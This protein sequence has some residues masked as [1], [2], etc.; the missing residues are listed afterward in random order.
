MPL[1][2]NFSSSFLLLLIAK[3]LCLPAP[4]RTSLLTIEKTTSWEYRH[5]SSLAICSLLKDSPALLISNA[6]LRPLV[7]EN[8]KTSAM[9]EKVPVSQTATVAIRHFL[10][11]DAE[12]AAEAGPIL[13]PVVVKV[14]N[15]KP[16]DA[17]KAAV[18]TLKVVAKHS[19][20]VIS[21]TLL[22][23][24]HFPQLI[25]S[26]NS[27]LFHFLFFFSSGDFPTPEVDYPSPHARRQ[28][29]ERARQ[30]CL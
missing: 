7:L 26:L 11:F 28:G 15:E 10:N 29:K 9:D 1:R 18:V 13:I 22:P 20:A 12:V 25:F 27:I 14:V 3:S 21:R 23:L 30:A 4:I 8:L 19:P 2:S 5:G 24:L 17:K 16:L 6:E